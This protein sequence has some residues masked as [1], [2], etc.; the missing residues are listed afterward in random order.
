VSLARLTAAGIAVAAL[1][2]LWRSADRRAPSPLVAPAATAATAALPGAAPRGFVLSRTA[3]PA[4]PGDPPFRDQDFP[5]TT[6]MADGP[7]VVLRS[8]AL[9]GRDLEI[10]LAT[11]EPLA[12]G[13]R[14]FAIVSVS[15][16]LGN[17]VIDC[18]W[19]DVGFAG[20]DARKLDCELPA[21]VA[22]PLT[23]SGHQLSAP[24]FVESPVVVAIDRR[25]H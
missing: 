16:A 20:D 8:S 6:D 15:D 23:I 22:L 9:A 19:R 12:D 4:L 14:V 21:G 18:T 3:V 24:S 17:T 1:A 7:L 13:K 25:A 11:R 10:E 2:L 5:L